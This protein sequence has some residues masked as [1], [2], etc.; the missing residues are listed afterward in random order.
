MSTD[1][2]VSLKDIINTVIQ[3][4]IKDLQT[5]FCPHCHGVIVKNGTQ[6]G[7]QRYKCKCCGS[8]FTCTTS[9]VMYRSRQDTDTWKEVIS[10]TV[11]FISIDKTAKRL[12]LSHDCVFHMRHK[13]LAAMEEEQNAHHVVLLDVI[14]CDETFFLESH[15][16]SKTPDDYWCGP[17]KHGAKAQ[18]RGISNEYICICTGVGREEEAVA[19]SLNR[20][21]PDAS[22]LKEV[23]EGYLDESNLVICDGL[24]SYN[25]LGNEY[26]CTVKDVNLEGGRFFHL[27]CVNGFHSF[28]KQNYVHYRGVATKYLNCYNTLFAK[29]YRTSASCPESIYNML[30]NNTQSSYFSKADLKALSLLVL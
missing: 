14:E 10:D 4:A 18:K 22:E 1:A 25:I 17:R 20:A 6:C 8:T 26:G 28:I 2:L 23:F 21:K 7:K 29:M 11:E 3:P 19:K 5:E 9:T 24:K 27:N 15:K 12:G 16:G 13:I 30:F